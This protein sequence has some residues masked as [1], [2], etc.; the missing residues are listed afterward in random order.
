MHASQDET[1]ILHP[2]SR[3]L[4]RFW[5]TMRAERSAPSRS[6]LD[7]KHVKQLVPSL[8]IA[9]YATRQ[10]S[11]RWR[12]AGTAICDLYRREL[13]GSSLLA[14]W[15]AFEADVV[16]RFMSSTITNRQPA[17][18]RFRFQ[19]DMDQV[20]G[21]EMA[22]FPLLASDGVTT[23]IF[24]GVFPFRDISNLGYTD[25]IR[26][27]IG[28]ARLVWTEN[29]ISADDRS[30]TPAPRRFQVITGGLDQR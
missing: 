24:G 19:T 15:D 23:H 18:L 25:I 30:M 12:L 14:G 16:R 20:I 27:E 28:A 9:E 3:M 13:T 6:D 7:L 11:F 26:M 1:H 2:S 10:R 29:L 17:I 21:A 5:E 22:A 4:F 8:F